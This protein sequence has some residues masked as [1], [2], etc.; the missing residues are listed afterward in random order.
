MKLK[1]IAFASITII[2]FSCSPKVVPPTVIPPA[3]TA[4]ELNSSVILTQNQIEGK[5]L[6][7]GNCAKC[8]E[9]YKPSTFTAE[10]W[11][12]ILK[13]MQPKARISDIERE[14]IYDYVTNGM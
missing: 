2:L 8:H 1:S 3:P 10:K 13:W 12:S 11:S 7:E 6:F 14:K 4:E 5:A 9:L